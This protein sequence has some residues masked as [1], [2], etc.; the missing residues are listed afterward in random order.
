MKNRLLFLIITIGALIAGCSDDEKNLSPSNIDRDKYNVADFSSPEEMEIRNAFY[1]KIGSYIVFNDS[2]TKRVAESPAGTYVF[3]DTIDLN[4]AASYRTNHEFYYTKLFT[5]D[6]KR[7]AADF[8]ADE[9]LP[10]LPQE[11]YPYSFFVVDSLIM[12]RYF[13]DVFSYGSMGSYIV[14]TM[15]SWVCYSTTVVACNGLF[16][17]DA[18]GRE[19]HIRQVQK[20]I[21]INT[22]NTLLDSV[23]YVDFIAINDEY[24]YVKQVYE[25]GETMQDW[26]LRHGFLFP[27][28]STQDPRIWSNDVAAYIW[29]MY[30][31]TKEEFDEKYGQWE[32][33]LE[34]RDALEKCLLRK[35]IRVY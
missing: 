34:R 17:M 15:G 9:V 28:W 35:N 31:M 23:D 11:F 30:D 4:Y 33:I 1:E 12:N 14:D 24:R 25:E 8:L 19:A 13:L 10:R 22:Y 6:E 5:I 21:L 3:V 2:L 29:E 16:E 18:A 27:V 26:Y 20:G 32:I 7:A